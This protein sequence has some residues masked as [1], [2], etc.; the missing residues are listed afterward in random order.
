MLS[1][2]VIDDL[3][4]SNANCSYFYFKQDDANKST[5]TGCLLSLAFQ[6]AQKDETVL[7]RISKV[8]GNSETWEQLD[9]RTLWR[10][11]FTGCI[12]KETNAEPHY[13]VIDALDECRRLS[14][15][16]SLLAKAPSYLL[17]FLTSRNSAEVHQNL[18]SHC[19]TVKH[20]PVQ[21]KDTL[22][23]LGIYIDSR[24]HSFPA[25]DSESRRD[26]RARILAKSS[27]SFLWTSLVV[28]ELEGVYSKEAIEEVLN[29]VPPGMNELYTRTIERI[30]PTGF[31]LAQ[32]AFTWTLLA[33]RPLSLEE[34]K[35]AIKLDTGETVYSLAN[36]ISS[37]C[38]QLIA[39]R[40]NGQ[41]QW[42]HQTAKVF[43]GH[44]GVVPPLVIDKLRS[45]SRIAELCL[46]SLNTSLGIGLRRKARAPLTS[47]ASEADIADYAALYFSD[48]LQNC[49]S[50]TSTAWDLLDEF[51][52]NN[53]LTWIEYLARTGRLR[54]LT[55][56]AKNLKSYLL[57]RLELIEPYSKE[58]KVLEAW[59]HDLIRLDAKFR[60][61][62]V[63]YPSAINTVIPA[64]CPSE[65][66]ISKTYSSRSRGII[67]KGLTER[68]WDE[69]LVCIEYPNEQPS[70]VAHGHG[71]FAVAVWDGTIFLYLRDSTEL[72]AALPHGELVNILLFSSDDQYLASCG[73]HK[74]MV[75]DIKTQTQFWSFDVQHQPLALA[76]GSDNTY[77]VAVTQGNC[78]ISWDLQDGQ[79]EETIW[80]WTS[81]FQ[82]ET[83]QENPLLW[84]VPVRAALS[85][86]C[87]TLAVSCKGKHIYLFDMGTN[88][89]IGPCSRFP[90][91]VVVR[92]YVVDALAFNPSPAIGVLVASYGDGGLAL[93]DQKTTELRYKTSNVF[94]H[95]LA[96]SP[97]GR[98][99]I[100]GSAHGI[101]KVYEF[102][103]AQGTNLTPIY[104]V[105]AF[106]EG[107]HGL[108]FSNDSRRFTDI[109][110]YRCRIWEP[111]VLI[112]N[113]YGEGEP[114]QAVTVKPRFMDL[115]EASPGSEI[116]AICPHPSGNYLF[117][118]KQD[119]TVTYFDVQS[120]AQRE[121][122]S[123]NVLEIRVIC[124]AY[125]QKKEL[126]AVADGSQVF[127]TTLKWKSTSC[128]PLTT[129]MSVHISEPVRSLLV[130]N[131]G[132]RLLV[133][134]SKS[135][136][137]WTMSGTKI[138]PDVM[139]DDS[140][141]R[142]CT[143]I[144]HLLDSDIF[145]MLGPNRTAAYPWNGDSVNEI[146]SRDI[147]VDGKVEP[148]LDL[149]HLAK[150]FS[151][152]PKS[153]DKLFVILRK[154]HGRRLT[155]A[156]SELMVWDASKIS[157]ER[158][159]PDKISLPEQE[160]ISANIRQLICVTGSVVLFLDSDLWVC[161]VDIARWVAER[162]GTLRHFFLLPEWAENGKDFLIE[163]L[164]TRREFLVVKKHDVV[165][166]R[167][168]LDVEIPLEYV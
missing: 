35:S 54:Y 69:C 74:V 96:C 48:H 28:R 142:R 77:L 114:S 25:A 75:W 71:Y 155:S 86:D 2:Y 34:L 91:K 128:E 116:T 154:P 149:E 157:L 29:K 87:S 58:K 131:S 127:M 43:L 32:S 21:K 14:V 66:M 156:L 67:V 160:H 153:P 23:G 52:E 151:T 101:I 72:N 130:N 80:S 64:L 33:I 111:S 166:I 167:R 9:E 17:I 62:L 65:S 50:R 24:I 133:R 100:T 92:E 76:F 46:R 79:I 85:G 44:Q 10:K 95:A 118:G 83:G 68:T 51:L 112:S 147:R 12:F 124:I 63:V 30:P 107:I 97:D 59:A 26:L 120:A 134:S 42:I 119:G 7:R 6:M 90:G 121:V 94:A 108:A 161:S 117:C 19:S 84:T 109:G 1:S 56:T 36:A 41:V 163:Y 122:L 136:Q 16:V 158:E 22:A 106:E 60:T 146:G 11:V 129:I 162:Q 61:V 40:Q 103:G 126:L 49:E 104:P 15:L 45:H 152:E 78:T 57:R 73:S 82:E 47:T 137:V 110:R 18:I 165:V 31:K 150:I 38:G 168:G 55:R 115:L 141:D 148:V 27:D 144:N 143:F 102:S 140:E 53:V 99:L 125:C 13:W 3:E 139:L 88:L 89:V 138:N 20:Y 98:M 135:A 123:R 81:R 70:A 159:W 8:L 39:A 132:T 93:F 4:E 105:N 37:I 5:I 164:P 113:D 145:L